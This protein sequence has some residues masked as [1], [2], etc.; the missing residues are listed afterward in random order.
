VAEALRL[1]VADGA[2]AA[3]EDRAAAMRAAMRAG[4]LAGV[5][6]L[7]APRGPLEGVS[8]TVRREG[9]DVE[10]RGQ[11]TG[12]GWRLPGTAGVA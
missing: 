7:A 5:E 2:L 8:W 10:G 9:S 11:E 3:A 4:C 6:A 12:R 1:M